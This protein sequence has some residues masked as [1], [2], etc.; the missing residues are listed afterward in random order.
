MGL[1]IVFKELMFKKKDHMLN[2]F[3]L[4]VHNHHYCCIIDFFMPPQP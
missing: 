4:L 2:L 3:E 1:Q